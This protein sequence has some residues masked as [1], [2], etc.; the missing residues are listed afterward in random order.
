M[1]KSLYSGVSGMRSNQIKM[2]VIGNN[3]ANVNTTAFKASRVKFQDMLN[4][5]LSTA[6]APDDSGRGGKNPKQVGLGTT[7]SSVDTIMTDGALQPTGRYLDFAIENDGFFVVAESAKIVSGQEETN[8]IKFTRDGAFYRDNE[9]N[10][11]N[12]SGYKVMGYQA[13]PV[14]ATPTS[15]TAATNAIEAKG[16]FDEISNV[17]T[18]N[19]TAVTDAI[20]RAKTIASTIAT[21][22]ADD[23]ELKAKADA[24]VTILNATPAPD[25]EAAKNAASDIFDVAEALSDA[26]PVDVNQ[27]IDDPNSSNLKTLEIPIKFV[28]DDITGQL[29]KVDG[30]FSQE[31]G[32]NETLISL[33]TFNVD[34]SGLITIIC[35]DQKSYKI[36]R[37][38]IAKFNNPEGLDKLGSNTYGAT[39][40]S[41]EIQYGVAG[42]DAFG[43]IQ[44]GAL[45]M[46]NVD[47]ANEFTEMIITSRAYQAN[48]RSITTSD[49]MLQELLNL[50]R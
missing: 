19:A 20:N 42:S 41:G 1:L 10:L 28:K 29:V 27:K 22:A 43:S 49:E 9:G 32:A 15:I 47:L 34:A 26:D 18:S 23:A 40:N 36:G 4:D 35:S 8:G 37:L 2:D 39:S 14:G 12:A 33:E 11:V 5:T 25:A 50:K 6:Q 48:S 17:D 44:Q 24:A 3:I 16:A 21:G 30:E 7:V 38:A 13:E 45:E 31:A 46:G